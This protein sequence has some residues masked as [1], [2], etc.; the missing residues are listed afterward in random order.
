MN[1]RL[2]TVVGVTLLLAGILLALGVTLSVVFYD[3]GLLML[4]GLLLAGVPMIL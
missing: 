1:R 2:G 3:A 4:L